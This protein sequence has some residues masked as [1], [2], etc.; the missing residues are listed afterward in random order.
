VDIDHKKPRPWKI[1]NPPAPGGHGVGTFCCLIPVWVLLVLLTKTLLSFA[2]SDNYE[3]YSFM[4]D[5]LAVILRFFSGIILILLIFAVL[6]TTLDFVFKKNTE[7]DVPEHRHNALTRLRGI[8]INTLGFAYVIIFGIWLFLFVRQ[9]YAQYS[10]VQ[11]YQYYRKE[12]FQYPSMTFCTVLGLGIGALI[13]SAL[14]KRQKLLRTLS[15]AGILHNIFQTIGTMGLCTTLSIGVGYLAGIDFAF[16]TEWLLTGLCLYGIA[17][18][19]YGMGRDMI[20]GDMTGTFLYKPLLS[21]PENI[22]IFDRNVSWEERTGLS[23]KTLWSI[24]YAVRIIPWMILAGCAMLFLFSSLYTIEPYQEA[25]L[26][27]LGSL[28]AGSVKS[29]GLHLKLPWPIDDINIYDVSRIRNMQIGYIPS[30]SLNYLWNSEHGGSEYTLLLGGGSEMIAVNMRISYRISSLYDYVTRYANG[31]DFLAS[32]MYAI[33]MKKTVPSD[34]NTVLGVDRNVLSRE[35]TVELSEYA[36][37]FSLGIHI[38]GIIIENIHPPIELAEVYHGVIGSIIQKETMITKAHA[39]AEK[40]LNNALSRR[41][42]A[43]LTA[44]ARQTEKTSMARREMAVYENAFLASELSPES[45]KLHKATNTY[46]Y[47]IQNERLYV[48]SSR[49]IR[50]MDRYLI[51][52]GFDLIPTIQGL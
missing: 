7:G 47:L 14:F 22:K 41:E 23:F 17:G 33:L 16:I 6:R 5:H 8:L 3:N 31:E 19:L 15:C 18:L 30:M 36:E 2:W 26:Y 43:V 20:R 52:N 38:D 24:K 37:I 42:D 51:T 39:D 12:N 28:K 34:L 21:L 4:L 35:L 32:G 44:T 13:L 25:L 29:P 11:F 48:F 46:R 45:Y 1:S 9:S 50:D 27:R 40:M 49:T 10:P